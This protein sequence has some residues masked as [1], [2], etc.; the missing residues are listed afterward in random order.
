ME[1]HPHA[2]PV[3]PFVEVLRFFLVD[4]LDD[5]DKLLEVLLGD[6]FRQLDELN[7]RLRSRDAGGLVP[8][9]VALVGFIQ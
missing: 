3:L 8:V 6:T 7:G 5:L 2:D 9:P 4:V 1:P